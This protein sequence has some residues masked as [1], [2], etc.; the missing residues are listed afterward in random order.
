M[1]TSEQISNQGGSGHRI[2]VAEDNETNLILI[3][4]M[5]SIQNHQVIVAK[6]GQ[7]AFDLAL[8][9]KPELIIMDVRMPKIDGL[10]VTQR[11]RQMPE[12]KDT[13]IIALTASAGKEARKKCLAAGCTDYLAKP[14]KSQE[15]FSMLEK[16]FK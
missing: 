1:T 10:E 16:Y 3:V 14:I 13:P 7:E 5:L 2:L 4:E 8:S 12:F 15:L 9:E 11:L 6:N